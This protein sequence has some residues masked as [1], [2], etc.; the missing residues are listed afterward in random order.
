MSFLH[1]MNPPP[2]RINPPAHSVAE[3]NLAFALLRLPRDRRAD[4]LTFYR[5]CRAIDDIADTPDIPAEEKK[6]S[7]ARW[8][9]AVE[10]GEGLPPEL[11]S[12]IDRYDIPRPLLCEIIHGCE[13]DIEPIRFATYDELL[14]YCWQ[15]ACAVGLVSIRIF[16]C[17]DPK[18]EIYATKLGYALQLTNILRDV[19]EDATQGRIY[20]PLEDL[21]RF[22]VREEEI[23]SARPG[24]RFPELMAFEASRARTFFAEASQ[25][26][27]PADARALFPAEIMRTLYE[28]LLHRME[29]NGYNVFQT[30]L[31]L[32]RLEKTLTVLRLTLSKN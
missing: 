18:S 15:V 1:V 21:T 13:R 22:E 8:V 6:A 4:A 14:A 2:L 3:S 7:L 31:R 11:S 10:N 29:Q 5:F 12:I 9:Q 19:A 20:L 26:L 30:R 32:S 23:L 28:K 17:R 24:Q 25:G 27:P 16:G